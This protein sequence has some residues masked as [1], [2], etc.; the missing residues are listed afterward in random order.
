VATAIATMTPA[1]TPYQYI[2]TYIARHA[3]TTYVAVAAAAA[4]AAAAMVAII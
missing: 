2:L 1:A 4:A 3:V